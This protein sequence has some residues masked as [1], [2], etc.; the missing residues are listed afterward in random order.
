MTPLALAKF[1]LPKPQ[2]W[3]YGAAEVNAFRPPIVA[4]SGEGYNAKADC[5]HGIDLIKEGAAKAKVED[6][7]AK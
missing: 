7:T 2:P 5:Q 4:T 3:E 6:T 1:G